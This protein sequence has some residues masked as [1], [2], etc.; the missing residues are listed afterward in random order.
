M[1]QTA[2]DALGH[3]FADATTE[4]PKTCKT[5]GATEGDK[6]PTPEEPEVP[7]EPEVPGSDEEPKDEQP[8][9]EL[10]FFQRIWLAIVN[11]FKKL[12]GIK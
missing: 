8:K 4:A 6:L 1:T 2:V 10:D 12:F 9:E 3:D 11:F 5:C 7:D